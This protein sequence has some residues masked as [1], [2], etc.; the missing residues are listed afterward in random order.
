[1]EVFLH[2]FNE[3]KYFYHILYKPISHI[4]EV[5]VALNVSPALK[6]SNDIYMFMKNTI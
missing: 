6:Y 1:M 2:R 4:H 3:N 5:P